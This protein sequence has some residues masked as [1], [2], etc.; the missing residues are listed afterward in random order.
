[1]SADPRIGPLIFNTWAGYLLSVIIRLKALFD[2][3]S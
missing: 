3:L 2:L 1:M